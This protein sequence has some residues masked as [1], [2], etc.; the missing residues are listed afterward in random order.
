MEKDKKLVNVLELN[1]KKKFF[2]AFTFHLLLMTMMGGVDLMFF[3]GEL[4]EF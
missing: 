4:Y 1:R 3:V 2:M